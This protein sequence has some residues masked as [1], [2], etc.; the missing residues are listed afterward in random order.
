MFFESKFSDLIFLF[1]SSHTA[2]SLLKHIRVIPG[3][4]GKWPQESFFVMILCYWSYLFFQLMLC[5]M[6]SGKYMWRFPTLPPHPF[7][8]PYGLYRDHILWGRF[9]CSLFKDK[10]LSLKIIFLLS[11]VRKWK[12]CHNTVFFSALTARKLRA[13]SW[14]I[15]LSW[16]LGSPSLSTFFSWFLFCFY[17]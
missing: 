16:E 12:V 10:V 15:N 14:V 13:K 4:C 1:F 11:F 17:P 7:C 5:V 8:Y 6:Y 9:L 3:V 2:M